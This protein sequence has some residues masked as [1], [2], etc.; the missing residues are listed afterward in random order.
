MVV[1]ILNTATE[2]GWLSPWDPPLQWGK[3]RKRI[4]PVSYT[5]LDVYK[6]Q[7]FTRSIT[8][9][10][11]LQLQRKN[12]MIAAFSAFCNHVTLK[13]KKKY[14]VHRMSCVQKK[15]VFLPG[16]RRSV[17]RNWRSAYESESAWHDP[18]SY[19]HLWE[20][21]WFFRCN[22]SPLEPNVFVWL[23]LPVLLNLWKKLSA[24]YFCS[25]DN[26]FLIF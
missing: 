5:H 24:E 13:R 19:T 11:T 17:T 14:K 22:D 16:Y 21:S 10:V 4:Y 1:F 3:V 25:T 18:V 15:R 9:L 12:R 2:S 26:Y 6:R 20:A 7:A 8:G 23:E